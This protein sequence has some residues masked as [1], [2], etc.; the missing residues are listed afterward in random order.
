MRHYA[1]VAQRTAAASAR[2][3][4]VKRRALVAFRVKLSRDTGTKLVSRVC[5]GMMNSSFEGDHS[6]QARSYTRPI[7]SST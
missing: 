7:F 5:E 1:M 2:Q 4:D 6:E 3:A